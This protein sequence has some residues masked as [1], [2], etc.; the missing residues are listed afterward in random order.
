MKS[1]T[2]APQQELNKLKTT[3]ELGAAEKELGKVKQLS[4]QAKGYSKDLKN[5]SKGNIDSVKQIST[6]L[7]NKAIQMGG[8]KDLQG[9]VKQVDQYK[10]MAAKGNDPE[11]M[12]KLAVEQAT[13]HFAGKEKEL[14]GAMSQMS[15]L[16]KKYSSLGSLSDIA[17]MSRNEM[18]GKPLIERIVPGITMQ[19]LVKNHL[20]I[21][22]N[23]QAGYRFTGKLTAGLGWNERVGFRHY[24]QITHQDRIY[25]PRTFAEFKLS[26]GFV[27]H[28]D[29]EMMN[30][31]VPSLTYSR[32][33]DGS[34]QWAWGLFL[35]MKKEYKLSKH[36]RGNIQAMYNFL[37][38]VY[39]TNPY[40][41][42][43][44]VRMG[45]EFR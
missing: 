10:A 4:G 22:F 11:A 43:F 39:K 27:A 31:Y 37:D 30:T 24:Y 3:G 1:L 23:P 28:A 38:K 40:P 29:L 16:K 19:V 33:N 7:E 12:K 44:N 20:M 14:Q 32:L 26:R 13:N 41:D 5:L 9:Q 25:G 34:R 45:I 36:I 42:R 35:G 17:K 2:N 18:H 15:K 6:S 8:M 21:D